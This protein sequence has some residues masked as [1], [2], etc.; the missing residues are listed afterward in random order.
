LQTASSHAIGNQVAL[1][2]SDSPADL[3]Q[4]LIVGV[5]AH[6]SLDK[7]QQAPTFFQLLNQEHLVDILPSESIWSRHKY[8]IKV[9]LSSLLT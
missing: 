4:Q 1:I 7:L 5:L 9:R 2:F 3:Q 8:A 6:R